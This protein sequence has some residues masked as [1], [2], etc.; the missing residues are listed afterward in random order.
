MRKNK[1]KYYKTF[2]SIKFRGKRTCGAWRE[3]DEKNVP[4]QVPAVLCNCDLVVDLVIS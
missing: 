3:K 4:C 2:S 1:I